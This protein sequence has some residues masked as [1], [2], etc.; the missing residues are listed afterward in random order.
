MK[1]III[2]LVCVFGTKVHAEN[3]DRESWSKIN[4]MQEKIAHEFTVVPEPD[5]L[6]ELKASRALAGYGH[7]DPLR[8][9]PS[10][11]LASAVLFFDQN[12]SRFRNQNYISVVDF[13]PRSNNHRLFIIN[14][15]TGSIQRYRTSHGEG[16]DTNRD[17]YAESFG[18]VP[19]SRKSSLGYARTA[20]VYNG[21]FG[22]SLRLDGLSST[23]T[24]IRE[25]AIVFHGWTKGVEA[26]QI[27]ALSWGC[28][29]IDDDYRDVVIDQIKN[30]SLMLVH[31]SN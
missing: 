29:T 23:N 1:S 30:G 19:G 4:F 7:L 11:L 15:K 25:R 26:N 21:S 27:Q 18:N 20:E 9:V 6:L 2:L 8:L 3:P 12:K 14:L 31:L 13:A 5:Q 22:R 17:G 10:N 16:S 24:K 28:V